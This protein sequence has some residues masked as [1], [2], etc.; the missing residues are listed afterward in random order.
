MIKETLINIAQEKNIPY[1]LEVL[2]F[3]GTDSGAIHT[4][5][6]V[7]PLEEYQFQL[8]MYTPQ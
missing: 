3:G 8:D 6:V 7:L 1:Q 4:I 2:E 5:K